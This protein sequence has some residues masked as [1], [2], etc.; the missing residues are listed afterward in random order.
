[1]PVHNSL[2]LRYDTGTNVSL[3]HVALS[4]HE[5]PGHSFLS[6]VSCLLAP[7]VVI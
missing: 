2:H 7:E 1:M 3:G 5:G 4:L 6:D